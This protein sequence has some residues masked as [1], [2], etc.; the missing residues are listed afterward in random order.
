MS[1]VEGEYKRFREEGL[2]GSCG[3]NPAL[4]GKSKCQKCLENDASYRRDIRRLGVAP[5]ASSKEIFLDPSRTRVGIL[6]IEST[7]LRADFAI[8]FCVVVKILG[9]SELRSFRIDLKE[10]DM[11]SAE[12]K[13]LR[14]VNKYIKTLDGLVTYYGAR[15]DVP[16]LR[17]R[18]FT[19]G[20]NP[21]PKVRH[22][23]LYFAV[24]RTLLLSRRRLQNV[25][26]MF[27][28]SGE[29]IPDKGRVEPAK[30]VRATYS[31]DMQALDEIVAHCIE[32]VYA[33]EAALLKLQ[34]FVTDRVLRQ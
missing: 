7:N 29:K 13:M 21:F 30:W 22:L 34:N 1:P 23:D 12:R 15:F 31:R 14:E 27:Q 19:Q 2:C 25:I 8:T 32:D 26:E 28:A 11:I 10:L 4:E 18:M 16:F 20:I 9:T 17:T 3:S 24:K 6:D 33:L 5:K